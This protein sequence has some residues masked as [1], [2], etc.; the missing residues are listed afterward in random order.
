M[1]TLTE[2]Q[3]LEAWRLIRLS[4]CQKDGARRQDEY[5]ALTVLPTNDI[6]GYA[7]LHIPHLQMGIRVE[8]L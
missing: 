1:R 7:Q 2:D 3:G 5:D 6:K 8:A 4:V